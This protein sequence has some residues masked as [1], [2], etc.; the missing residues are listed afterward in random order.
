VNVGVRVGVR[1]AVIV[2]VNVRVR[3]AVRVLVNVEVRVGV[4]VE[5]WVVVE[6]AVRVAVAVPV[7]VCVAV[8]VGVGGSA[9]MKLTRDETSLSEVWATKSTGKVPSCAGAGV[10][11]KRDATVPKPITPL[12]LALAGTPLAS[13]STCSAGMAVALTSSWMVCPGA[14]V[15]LISAPA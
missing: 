15:Q 5:V 3:V 2:G 13:S 8:R 7:F 14:M 4:R 12:K 6:V 9:T 11:E 10:K 1:V